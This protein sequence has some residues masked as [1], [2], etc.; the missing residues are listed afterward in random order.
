MGK[1]ARTLKRQ[2]NIREIIRS[3]TLKREWETRNSKEVK[4]KEHHWKKKKIR[5]T[6]F[7]SLELN[8]KEKKVKEERN[9]NK[10]RKTITL[11]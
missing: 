10:K 8:A 6:G 4:G 5:R 1:S 7:Q 9:I 3:R 2:I 11:K